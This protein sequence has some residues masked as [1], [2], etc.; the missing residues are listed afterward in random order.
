MQKIIKGQGTI[1]QADEQ[2]MEN[3]CKTIFLITG[4]HYQ[5]TGEFVDLKDGIVDHYIKSGPNV[6]EAEVEE[7]YKRFLKEPSAAVVAIGGGSV[8]DLAKAII[9]KQVQGNQEIPFF[10][11][12][13]TTAGS[14]SE[15]TQFAVIYKDKKKLSL[16]HAALLPQL[17]I[18]DPNLI[19][20]LSRYQFAVSGMDVL[21]QSIEA[22]WNKNVTENARQY[23]TESIKLWNESFLPAVKKTNQEV[24]EKMLMS[25]H[26]AGKAISITRSTGPHAMSYYLT[27]HHDVPHGHAVALFL[28]LFFIYNQP[29]PEIC[30]TIGAE[31]PEE[32]KEIVQEI[33][34]QAGLAITLAELGIDKAAIADK[35]VDEVN[36]DRFSNNPVA[37]N[38]EMLIGLIKTHL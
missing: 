36:E 22:L 12:A 26:L 29:S 33:M 13:P 21:C 25:S 34:K 27:S 8:M 38:R 7:A 16:E 23:A 10:L 18:L 1:L 30:A 5:L 32:A 11:A 14:G 3:G 28:P 15:A 9:Y 37:F 35:L 4:R 17:V 31:N 20:S 2:L 24:V 19:K 6:E